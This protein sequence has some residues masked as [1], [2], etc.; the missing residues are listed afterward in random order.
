MKGGGDCQVDATGGR[1]RR[2]MLDRLFGACALPQ[3][4]PGKQPGS[5]SASRQKV[6]FYYTHIHGDLLPPIGGFF[7]YTSIWTVGMVN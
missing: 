1:G 6:P 7:A 4:K 5:S 2:L 3:P